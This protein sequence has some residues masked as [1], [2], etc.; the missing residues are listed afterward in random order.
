MSWD[1]PIQRQFLNCS[2]RGVILE[3]KQSRNKLEYDTGRGGAC[4]NLEKKEIAKICK[5]I[6]QSEN[7]H[8]SKGVKR[9]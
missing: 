8:L 5:Y 9:L 1:L 4:D 7:I 3:C 2:N 6:F